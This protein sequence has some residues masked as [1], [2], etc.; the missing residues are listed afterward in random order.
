VNFILSLVEAGTQSGGEM[1]LSDK[2]LKVLLRLEDRVKARQ[3]LDIG[4]THPQLP[5]TWEE[6]FLTTLVQNTAGLSE[7]Q[8]R[9]LL[10]I[11]D[12]MTAQAAAGV[13]VSPLRATRRAMNQHIRHRYRRI[14]ESG[15]L[16]PDR[17]GH[18]DRSQVEPMPQHP[19]RITA[20]QVS[21]MPCRP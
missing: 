8:A 5:S 15:L 13:P 20:N 7:K 3:L 18:G 21:R 2:Q 9:V 1:A 4:R 11:Q 14:P 19:R 16:R 10:R 12:K 6:E 17:I